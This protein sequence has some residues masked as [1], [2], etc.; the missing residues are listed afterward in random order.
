VLIPFI[1]YALGCRYI[2]YVECAGERLTDVLNRTDR[3][4]SARPS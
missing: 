4:S 1:G 3:S 2:G